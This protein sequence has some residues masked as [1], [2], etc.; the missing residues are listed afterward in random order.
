MMIY[1]FGDLLTKENE[2][3]KEVKKE[4]PADAPKE[5]P[6]EVPKEALATVPAATPVTTPVMELIVATEVVALDQV[7]PT[8]VLVYVA[9][10]FVQIGEVPEIV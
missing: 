3:V 10:A 2:E 4:Q 9:V 5:I 7:P 8:V 1:L 6:K